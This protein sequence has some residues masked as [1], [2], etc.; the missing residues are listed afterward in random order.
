MGTAI[1]VD[2]KFQVISEPAWN[3]DPVAE[4]TAWGAP[5]ARKVQIIV[6]SANLT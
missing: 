6:P 5:L 4:I 1:K 3:N 2:G